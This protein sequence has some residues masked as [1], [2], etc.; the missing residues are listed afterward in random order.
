MNNNMNNFDTVDAADFG[1][2]GATV[3]RKKADSSKK[4]LK[5]LQNIGAGI[6]A[7]V[8]EAER[9]TYGTKKDTLKFAGYAVLG[10]KKTDVK[11]RKNG[12][13][14][15]EKDGK[16]VTVA[17]YENIYIPKAVGIAF[18][19]TEDIEVPVID[20]AVT[21]DN[22][23]VATLEKGS[24]PV[25]A[26]QMFVLTPVEALYFCC[27]TEYSN[28]FV[29]DSYGPGYMH[30]NCGAYSLD[31][32]VG[33]PTPTFH[34]ESGKA[35]D[36]EIFVDKNVGTDN[37]P[38]WTV[39]DDPEYARFATYLQPKKAKKVSAPKEEKPDNYTQMVTAAAL[40]SLLGM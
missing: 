15:V 12:T 40:R 33:L 30:L 36:M 31:A 35:R 32:Q 3:E 29:T 7:T 14:Q 28:Q 19:S 2:N 10:S 25:A 21:T 22:V 8:S 1:V 9:A 38:K 13:K 18:V 34:L 20:I 23:N 27:R 16:M 17:N 11:R 4:V 6:L 39:G 5:E 24:R 37:E 26:G